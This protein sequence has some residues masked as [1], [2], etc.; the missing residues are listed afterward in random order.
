MTDIG[1]YISRGGS[2]AGGAHD[3]GLLERHEQ[4]FRFAVVLIRTWSS[5]G[6]HRRHVDGRRGEGLASLSV[7]EL[8]CQSAIGISAEPQPA[9]AIEK[10]HSVVGQQ[11]FA[12]T[13]V[14]EHRL[15]GALGPVRRWVSK[16]PRER[17]GISRPEGG[18]LLGP[19][20]HSAWLNRTSIGRNG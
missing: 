3:A 18:K 17:Q 19:G 14:S 6:W 2:G 5:A 1:L 15:A 12:P 4:A 10:G 20:A 8:D 16:S 11:C 7:V 13:C 9:A